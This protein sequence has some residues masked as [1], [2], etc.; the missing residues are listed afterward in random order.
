MTSPIKAEALELTTTITFKGIEYTIPAD[1]SG[2]DIEVAEL[3]EVGQVTGALRAL[4]GPD[5]YAI[6]RAGA[7]VSDVSDMLDTINQVL[8]LGN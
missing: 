5:Q 3:L 6:F 2:M 7:K 8:G 4:L 1:R